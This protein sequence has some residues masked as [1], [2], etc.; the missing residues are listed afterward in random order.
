L[1]T[2]RAGIMRALNRYQD[3]YREMS[4]KALQAVYPSL[5][6]ETGQQLDRAFRRDC[7]SYD[8]TFG[9]MQVALAA[10]DPTSAT[11]NVRST[12]T[13][14]P[15]SAQ[16]AQPQTVQDIFLLR[17]VGGEWLIDSAGTTDTNR[18]R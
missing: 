12:Y 9:N 15:K 5:P 13:C 18:R 6:R 16:A 3:A 14:Q 8:L 7:R 10:D 2:E 17:K 4:V 1:D 11:V